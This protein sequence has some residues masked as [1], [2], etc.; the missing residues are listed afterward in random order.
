MARGLAQKSFAVVPRRFE[1]ERLDLPADVPV[2]GH[3]PARLEIYLARGQDRAAIQVSCAG[4]LVADDLAELPALG[5]DEPPW[6][7]CDLTGVIDFAGFTVPPGT[8]RGVVPNAAAAAF[9][10]A[11]NGVA[12]RLRAEL[13]RLDRERRAASDRHVVA[14]LRKALRG[15]SQRLPHYDLPGVPDGGEAREA[16]ETAGEPLAPAVEPEA[17]AIPTIEEEEAPPQGALF[18]PGPLAQVTIVPARVGLVPGGERRIQAVASDADGRA[19]REGVTFTWR[20]VGDAVAV[21]GE[22]PR[23]AL[24]AAGDARLGAETTILVTASQGEL[25][26]QASALAVV[27]ESRPERPRE[28]ALGVPEPELVDEPNASWRSRWDGERWQVNASHEDYI[29]LRTDGR[30]RLRYLLA[31]LAKEIVG[32][33]YVT[34]GGG[35]LLEHL[36]A[37]LAHVERNLRGA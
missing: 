14:E 23:P 27:V 6:V 33:T 37:I 29:A 5:L 19:L 22:G 24:R 13:A 2:E 4:T 28:G 11:M 20:T 31:L 35:E 17:P 36:V 8:R 10:Q 25:Q 34:P 21:H 15:L 30:A 16:V 9:V 1:G 26:V 18:G 7:G 3:E 32:R 12:D